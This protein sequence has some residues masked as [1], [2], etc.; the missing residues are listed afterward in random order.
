MVDL[1]RFMCTRVQKYFRKA[2]KILDLLEK[3]QYNSPI[4]ARETV[5]I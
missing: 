2:A 4:N 1:P 3:L 5:N